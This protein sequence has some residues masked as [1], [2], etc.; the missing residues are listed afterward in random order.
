MS[1]YGAPLLSGFISNHKVFKD[2]RE[3]KCDIFSLLNE[4][5]CKNC[6]DV[7]LRPYL[8][9]KFLYGVD[10]VYEESVEKRI[11]EVLSHFH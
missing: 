1:K 3:D 10:L 9:N 4:W 2:T 11:N 6:D 8:I 7:T 5:I